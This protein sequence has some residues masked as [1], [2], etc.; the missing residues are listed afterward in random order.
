MLLYNHFMVET[1]LKTKLNIPAYRENQVPRPHLLKQLEIG[2]QGKLTLVSAPAG[3]GKTTLVSDWLQHSPVSWFSLDENDNDPTRFLLYMIT[4]LQSIVPVIGEA[5]L[6][7]AQV[8]QPPPMEVILTSLVNDISNLNQPLRLVLD[9]YHYIQNLAINQLMAFLLEHQ[10]DNLHLVI[11]SREDPA[12]PISRLRARAQI[13]E[14]RQGDL[15]FSPEECA[16]F[17]RGAMGLDLNDED[18]L[19]LERRTE[20]W[21]AGLQL[22]ALSMRGRDDLQGFVQGFTGSSRFILDYLIEE[23]FEGQPSEVKDFLLKTSIL[24]R[25]SGPL[26]DAV[27]EIPGSQDL[28]QTLEHTNLF[29]VALD[30]SRTWYRYHRLFSELLRHRLRLLSPGTESDLHQRASQWFEQQGLIPEAIFHALECED[31]GRGA[32]LIGRAAEGF[33]RRGE[34]ATLIGWFEKIPE[35]IVHSQPDL[36]LSYAWALL[37]EG[38]L[39]D[40]GKLLAFYE[41]IAKSSPTLLGQVTS[42]Q[43]FMARAQGKDDLVIE[44]SQQSLALLPEDDYTSRSTLAMNLGLVFW[45][46]GNLSEAIQPLQDAVENAARVDNHYARLTALV[47]LA[48]TQ[49]SRGSLHQPE[50]MYKSLLQNGK[51]IPILALASFDLCSIYYEWNQLEP[52]W[53]YLERGMEICERSGHREFK[54]AGHML[55]ATLMTAQGNMTGALKEVEAAQDLSSEF[56]QNTQARAMALH[57]QIALAMG[58][59]GTTERW[60]KQMPEDADAHSFYR[61]VCLVRVRLLVAKKEMQVARELL[62]DLLSKA[63]QSGWG[64]AKIAIFALRAVSANTEAEGLEI[65]SESLNLSQPEGFIRTYIDTGPLIV[66]LLK[67]AARQGIMPEY[68]GQI[69]NGFRGASQSRGGSSLPEPLS[70]REMEVLHLVAAGLSNREIAEQLILSPGTIKTHVHNICGKLEAR[71]RTEAAALAKELGLL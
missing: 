67:E 60:I 8:P 41:G 61:F 18:I 42:A 36:G 24:D 66:P 57:A 68:V 5:A 13:T 65:L 21:I 51:P 27:T 50:G 58:E 23:V 29:L 39:K 26:C 2:S 45:H 71:N 22:A 48:R 16:D 9:D 10:P 33:L 34:L 63:E 17:L 55:K 14:I 46:A 3:F 70:D 47:F 4:A 30:Q 1:I 12:F 6:G 7:M 54:N 38:R 20:G 69:L 28:L 40:A 44:K 49:V 43:A 62:D 52:A 59:I 56:N 35:Q 31:W 53:E 11:L 19:A 15:C 64:Y 25:L 32:M 37:L